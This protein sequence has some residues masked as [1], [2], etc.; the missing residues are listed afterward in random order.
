VVAFYE[1]H[2]VSTR[3]HTG[4]LE[5]ARRLFDLM[6]SQQKELVSENPLRVAVTASVE[7]DVS[8]TF[9]E[10]ASIVDISR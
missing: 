8:V 9:D 6:T 4:E 1:D 3:I 2:G 10:T 5:S 7:D